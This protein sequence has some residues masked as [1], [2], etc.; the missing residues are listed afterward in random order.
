MLTARWNIFRPS[1]SSP[2]SG[3]SGRP[4]T[5]QSGAWN[6]IALS[7]E[8]LLAVPE[9]ADAVELLTEPPAGG[10]QGAVPAL[11]QEQRRPFDFVARGRLRLA[12]RRRERVPDSRLLGGIAAKLS[13]VLAGA[14]L[15]RQRL[16]A[17]RRAGAGVNAAHVFQDVRLAAGALHFGRFAVGQV[18]HDSPPLHGMGK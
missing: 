8:E 18:G 13:Q 3:T 15:D 2:S 10:V 17:P 12:R 6:R 16:V 14:P 7:R 9:G 1:H 4:A 5:N 11:G